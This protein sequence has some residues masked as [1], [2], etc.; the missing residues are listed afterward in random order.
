MP[1]IQNKLQSAK[2]FTLNFLLLLFFILFFVASSFAQKKLNPKIDKS[3]TEVALFIIGEFAPTIGI[4]GA[5]RLPVIKK[6]KIGAGIL[7][8]ANI[9]GGYGDREAFGYGAVFADVL[10]LLGKR[11]KWGIEGQIGKGIYNRDVGID[12]IKG[13]IYYSVL[14]SYRAILTKKLIAISLFIGHR[15]FHYDKSGYSTS[16]DY[17]VLTGLKLGIV[18]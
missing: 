11:Q 4:Q 17:P 10:Q 13:G 8:G 3:E 14:F 6:T 15:S 2:L 12:K 16:S 7:Y 5:Y 1:A 9:E 18:F